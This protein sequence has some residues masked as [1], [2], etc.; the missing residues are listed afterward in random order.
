VDS[1]TGTRHLLH[2]DLSLQNV[3]LKVF[4]SGAVP[5]KLSDFGLVKDRTWDFT[6]TGTEMRGTIRD[7]LLASFKEYDTSNEVYAVGWILQYIFTGRESLPSDDGDVSRIIRRCTASDIVQRY[8]DV[9]T[10]IGDLERLAAV[11][12]DATA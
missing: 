4:A 7:P 11:P 12:C 10:I 2:R 6:R 8:P 1:V 5:V 3:L 9:R